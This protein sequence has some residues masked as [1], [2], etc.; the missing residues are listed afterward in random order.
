[1]RKSTEDNIVFK[2]GD[3]S[4]TLN[5]SEL[6]KAVLVL[7]AINHPLRKQLLALLVQKGSMKVT[8]IYIALRIEQSVASQHLAILRDTGVVVCEREGKFV[9][10]SLNKERLEQIVK[11]IEDITP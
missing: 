11:L 7:R 10:Y 2:N 5:Y 4:T 6:K 8:D 9:N 3:R 1:M